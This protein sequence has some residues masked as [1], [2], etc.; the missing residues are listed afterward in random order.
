MIDCII[1][2]RLGST[3]YPR[4]ILQK[5]SNNK[6]VLEFLLDQL[7]NSKSIDKIIIATTNLNEDDRIV[8]FCQEKNIYSYKKIKNYIKEN[9]D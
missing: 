4:K 9:I 8:N 3:R 6:T 2:A 7:Q 1:Q 5:I